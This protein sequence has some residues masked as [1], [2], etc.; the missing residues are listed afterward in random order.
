VSS[1]TKLTVLAV[2]IA[3]I[4]YVRISPLPELAAHSA[5]KSPVIM[6]MTLVILFFGSVLEFP[7][8]IWRVL[9]IV[10]AERDTLLA[11]TCVRLC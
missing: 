8:S 11:R 2:V 9:T 4:L 6:F 3:A 7:G 5:I 1:R 10:S